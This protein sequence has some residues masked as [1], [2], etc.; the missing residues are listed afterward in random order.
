VCYGYARKCRRNL[1][2]PK[3]G[4]LTT[5]FWVVIFTALLPLFTLIFHKDFTDQVQTWAAAAAGLA[6]V[7]YIISRAFVKSA[8][9]RAPKAAAAN[10]NTGASDKVAAG[11]VSNIHQ[12]VDDL[13]AKVKV[14]EEQLRSLDMLT[15]GNSQPS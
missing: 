6:T 7:A 13:T 14:L 12:T 2:E 3:T 8:Y 5:E 4:Y 9:A 11:Q 10:N 15:S 1:P